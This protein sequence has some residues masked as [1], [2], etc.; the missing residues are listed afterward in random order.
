MLVAILLTIVY[1]RLKKLHI[2]PII[3][4]YDLYPI[5]IF[6][7]FNIFLQ[8]NIFMHN[9]SY[10]QWAEIIKSA[11]L[12]LFIIPIINR[13][14]YKPGIIGSFFIIF[15]TVLNKIVIAANGGKMPIYPTLS[16]LTGYFDPVMFANNPGIHILGDETS[17]LI[18]LTDYIDTGY[19]IL[20][21]G[22][23]FIHAFAAIIVYY[24]IKS[25]RENSYV[26]K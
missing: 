23:L 25:F 20:S 12:F 22:D 13:K 21:L 1:A 10:I 4:A 16:K 15:G 11:Y 17:K 18:I 3:K 9:Y 8:V 26:R 7:L 5:F 2:K 14:L 6:E 19:S 24:T